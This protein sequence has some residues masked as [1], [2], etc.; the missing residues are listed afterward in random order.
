MHD[1]RQESVSITRGK[2]RGL[3]CQSP[4]TGSRARSLAS[5]N[6]TVLDEGAKIRHNY[7]TVALTLRTENC[8][9]GE[10]YDCSAREDADRQLCCWSGKSGKSGKTKRQ[11]LLLANS[12]VPP[13]PLTPLPFC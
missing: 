2:G 12:L 7:H 6:R 13:P 3:L 10:L 9:R 1:E 8:A 4:V 11:F 5:I